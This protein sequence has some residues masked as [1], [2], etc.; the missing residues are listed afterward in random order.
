MLENGGHG[1]GMGSVLRIFRKGT[2]KIAHMQISSQ[3][4]FGNLHFFCI[5]LLYLLRCPFLRHTMPVS[6]LSFIECLSSIAPAESRILLSFQAFAKRRSS[7]FFVF[8]V[9]IIHRSPSSPHGFG[10]Y[11]PDLPTSCPL[12]L[13]RIWSPPQVTSASNR[14]SFTIRT[15]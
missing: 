9:D 8:Q 7:P 12:L 14:F 2:T 11:I 15:M 13:S 5:F 10:F 4:S 3:K 1:L 6:L